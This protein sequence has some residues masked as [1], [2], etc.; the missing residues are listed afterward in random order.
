MRKR[1]QQSTQASTTKTQVTSEPASQ[2]APAHN[3]RR[4]AFFKARK[5][6]WVGVTL[7]AIFFLVLLFN[8]YFN[9]VSNA[10]INPQG[11]DLTT[12]YYLSGPDPYYNMRLVEQTS[13]TGKFPYYSSNDPLLNYPLGKSGGRAPLLVMSAI[14]FSKV[15]V[16]FMSE[17]DALGLAMQFVPALFG[18]LLIF[19]VY[20][21][22]KTI[23]GRKE[24][25]I[26]AL[27]IAII[28]IEISSGHGSAFALFD[29]DSFNLLLYFLTFVFFLK[30]IKETNRLQS[31]LYAILAGIPLAALSM[32]W[33]EAQF[34]YT[35]I[36][37]YVIVQLIF[38]IFMKKSET[39]FVTSSALTLFTGVLV[40]LP[41][42]LVSDTPIGLPFYLAAGVTV[43]GLVCVLFKRLN[44]PWVLTV[45]IIATIAGLAAA[46]LYVIYAFPSML[47][48]FLSPLNNISSILFGSGIYGS[49]VSLTIAEAGTYNIS[50]TVM[51]YGPAIYW[52]G[53]FGFVLLIWQFIKNR[54]RRDYMFLLT[55]FVIQIWLTST[56]G[57]FLNDMVP[58]I[59]LY[60]GWVIWFIVSKIDYRKMIK[61]IQN[62]G[63]G[64]RGIRRGVK[65]THI[66]GVLFV[67]FVILVPNVFLTL[68][69]AVPTAIT[70][71]G[72]S[73]FKADVFG[74]DFVGAFGSSSYKE[75]YW[76][77]AY[78]WLRQ[79]DTN[80]TP[81]SNKPAFISWWDY[82]FY[83]SAV[84]E[85][86]TVADNFQDGIPPA[87]NFHT[88]TSEKEGVAVW[89]VRLLH[90]NSLANGGHLSPDVE[91]AV[92]N[93]ITN[94]SNASK[95]IEWITNP[96]S[97][98]SYLGPVGA[99]YDAAVSEKVRVGSQYPENAAYHDVTSLLNASMTDEEITWLYHV[100]QLTTKKS[101]R[102]YGVEGYD[103]Q[104]FNIFAF[105]G[106]KSNSLIALRTPG[107]KIANPEDDFMQVKY[108]GYALNAD[109]TPG[110]NTSWTA[111]EINNMT[112]EQR[113]RIQITGTTT[114]YKQ[115]YFETM[116]Y[117]TYMGTPPTTDQNGELQ[118]PSQQIPTYGMRHFATEYVSPYPY[119][120]GGKSAVVIAKY[121]EGAY[122]N[123]TV[124]NITGTPMPY[125]HVIVLDSF[126][127]PHDNVYSDQNG[128]FSIISPAGNVTVLM[129]YPGDTLL[130][131]KFRL[132][133]TSNASYATITD[134][135]AM[136]TFGTDYQRQF[137]LSINNSDLNGY[138]FT[139]TN[140]NN[141]YQPGVDTPLANITVHLDDLFFGRSIPDVKTD[142]TGHYRFP[143][144]PPSKYNISAIEHGFTLNTKET[145][146][147]PNIFWQNL[148]KPLSGGLKGTVYF[149]ANTN[150]KVDTGETKANA[151]VT[152]TYTQLS[153]SR[154]TVGH[155]LTDTTGTYQFPNLAPGNYTLNASIR[156]TQT[157]YLDYTTLKQIT[158]R[159][160]VTS[161]VNLSIAYNPVTVTGKATYN[162]TG[163]K[164]IRITFVPDGTIQ[165][166]TAK[167]NTTTTDNNGAYTAIVLP[168]SYNI[169]VNYLQGSTPVYT[170][171]GKLTAT[172]G[173]G[174][175]IYNIA[176]IKNSTTVTG[177]TIYNQQKIANIT[178]TFAPDT[179]A[180][181][182]AIRAI[183]KSAADGS[184]QLELAPGQYN[185]TALG[186]VK[187]A[188]VNVTYSNL[189]IQHVTI[190]AGELTKV[191][192]IELRK[193][194]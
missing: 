83:E 182:T 135:E 2:A 87:A 151:N 170:Y 47:P 72:T 77:G 176:L 118:T 164:A 193:E 20:F 43:F 161:T 185:V 86:P 162:T 67:S 59:A 105:L 152:L 92:K 149:D 115:A 24:G 8:T 181:N 108:T 119:Y 88:A 186:V 131:N 44:L 17:S 96:K 57:R 189:N 15:L 50:R 104:I 110:Q 53:W 73:N 65:V 139:D 121:Y 126:G 16:P 94:A 52:L 12:K 167:Q 95:V 150:N 78:A 25:I 134:A 33:V 62:A 168:G 26:A 106:D 173:Q 166:N 184:F 56:A 145:D 89:I 169:T 177:L 163:V 23:F 136:R 63:G 127:F 91:S 36:A 133:Q 84:G 74:K 178:L 11:T 75:Q 153:G 37:I 51:S 107:K 140:K 157:G 6:L 141:T 10:N 32:V 76:V 90:A 18:A 155:Q 29:H 190:T 129:T 45:P 30:S 165:N 180:T 191:L 102:Y 3:R 144:I 101:I 174:K 42:I 142:A 171:K 4:F 158:I 19:P 100:V 159:A 103:E 148:S 79:Q 1:A 41:V 122:L 28:P 156:D 71:N 147:E 160:N 117:K 132:N 116:F 125:V 13:S 188:G 9:M 27:L 49:K 58:V 128:T 172:I 138:I 111:G 35:V 98:P 31:I 46:F 187:E 175:T 192:T 70:K 68:D 40:S 39:Q 97:S 123:G 85:H 64:L 81:D 60:A 66:I 5:S 38:D 14:G 143:S 99:Q 154:L 69:A 113:A 146:V 93:H 82:G 61:N 80:I 109:N 114:I 7:I 183:T 124:R 137:N 48:S 179:G 194:Q 55:L 120:G 130:L 21:I 112:T 54:D 22:G 34:L